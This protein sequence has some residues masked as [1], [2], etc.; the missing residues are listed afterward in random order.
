MPPSLVRVPRFLWPSSFFLGLG[1]DLMPVERLLQKQLF[2]FFPKRV[3]S[4]SRGIVSF[5][6][7]SLR[8][9]IVHSCSKRLLN[10][11]G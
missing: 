2:S 11:F 9:E 7:Q 8:V 6:V 3:W 10:T 1:Q 4:R 5:F